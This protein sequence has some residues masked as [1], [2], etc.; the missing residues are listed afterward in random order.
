MYDSTANKVSQLWHKR[1]LHTSLQRLKYCEHG[2]LVRLH[3]TMTDA[4]VD[5]SHIR[6]PRRRVGI[7]LLMRHV[8][9][10]KDLNWLYG[11]VAKLVLK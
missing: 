1:L 2:S 4:R 7:L 6:A 9:K 11:L 8:A 5:L 3:D 10:I